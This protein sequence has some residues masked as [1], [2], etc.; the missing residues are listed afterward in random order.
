MCIRERVIG[1]ILADA[2]L[3]ALFTRTILF[4]SFLR[5]ALFPLLV[6]AVLLPLPMDEL[7]RGICVLMTGMPIGSTTSILADK[8]GGDAVFSSEVAFTSTL[9]SIITIPLLTLLL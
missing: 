1:A 5:L 7:S 2:P 8:Y 3:Q 6:W 9:L 4:F